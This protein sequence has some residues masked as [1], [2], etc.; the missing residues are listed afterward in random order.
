MFHAGR[1]VG[2]ASVYQYGIR[3]GTR[4]EFEAGQHLNPFSVLAPLRA[5]LPALRDRP[6]YLSIDIDVLDPGI[7]PAVSTP[8]PGGIDYRELI[9]GLREL[10]GCQ[11]VG[12]DI[13]EYNPLANRDPAPASLVASLLRETILVA[14]PQELKGSGQ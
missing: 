11:I 12:A 3:S 2:A 10:A 8:E 5:A 13:V 14:C 9:A 7:M 1:I 6:I 4:E